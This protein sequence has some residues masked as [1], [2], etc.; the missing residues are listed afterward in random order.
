MNANLFCTSVNRMGTLFKAS[1][2]LFEVSSPEVSSGVLTVSRQPWGNIDAFLRALPLK[3]LPMLLEP[4]ERFLWWAPMKSYIQRFSSLYCTAPHFGFGSLSHTI[5]F[6]IGG[7]I[8]AL[9]ESPNGFVCHSV[10]LRYTIYCLT[11]GIVNGSGKGVVVTF[12]KCVT[13]HSGGKYIIH[14]SL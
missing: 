8:H 1:R 7:G 9:P 12:W 10:P 11:Y 3:D 5:L 2:S 14:T 6:F 13:I 4:F